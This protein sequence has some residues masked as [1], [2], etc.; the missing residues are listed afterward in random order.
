MS[1]LNSVCLS[2][3]LTKDAVVRIVNKEENRMAL[4]LSLAVNKTLK[5]GEE[6]VSYFDA[7]Y[8]TRSNGII[9]YLQ[10]GRQVVVQGEL[11][12]DRFTTKDG[13]NTSRVVVIVNSLTLVGGNKDASASKNTPAKSGEFTRTKPGDYAIGPE[14]YGDD[15][16]PF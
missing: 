1:D 3:R 7:T 15:D 4:A 13:T 6:L 5:N 12:Q 11:R 2:A 16:V 10:K 8:F 9:P 14:N